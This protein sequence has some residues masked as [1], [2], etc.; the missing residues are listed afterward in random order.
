MPI[1]RRLSSRLRALGISNNV[2]SSGASIGKRYARNDELGTPLGITVDFET[3][4]SGSITLRERDTTTQVRGSEDEVL[5]AVRNLIGA[6]ESWQQT[7]QRLAPFST[8]G[9][10]ND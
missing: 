7:T 5:H 8:Q 2:D 6:V 4:A 10:D 1:I 9:E 3:V